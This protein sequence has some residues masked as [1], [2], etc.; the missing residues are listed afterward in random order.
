MKKVL[1][2]ILVVILGIVLKVSHKKEETSVIEGEYTPEQEIVEDTSKDALVT[3][4][5]PN[6]ET[7]KLMP[8]AKPIEVKKLIENPYQEVANLF[9]Q[10][11]TDESLEA[12]IPEDTVLLGGSIEKDVVTLNFSSEIKKGER[13]KITEA[14][15]KTLTELAEVNSIKIIIEGNEQWN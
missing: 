11:P 7:G 13:A 3:V 9:M 1:I 14:L 10:G 4:Y 5:Y 6:K 2:A 12:V 8:E 15:S